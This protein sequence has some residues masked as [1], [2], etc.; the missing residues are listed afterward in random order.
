[1]KRCFVQCFS[2]GPGGASDY[3]CRN[4]CNFDVYGQRIMRGQWKH[5]SGRKC[6]A[7]SITLTYG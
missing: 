2:G 5:S 4:P 3:D 6:L 7:R 1:M